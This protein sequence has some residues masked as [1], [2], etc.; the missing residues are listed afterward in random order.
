MSTFSNCRLPND[1]III[2]VSGIIGYAPTFYSIL[3]EKKIGHTDDDQL[4]YSK[5][6]L[7]DSVSGFS[8]AIIPKLRSF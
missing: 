2:I 8:V 4:Y 7:S 5:I 3:N 1:S 6:Y